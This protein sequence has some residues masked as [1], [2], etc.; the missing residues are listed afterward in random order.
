[1]LYALKN[2]NSII[3]FDRKNYVRTSADWGVVD[4]THST[5]KGMTQIGERVANTSLDTR[6]IEIVGHIKAASA[7]DMEAKKTAL[8]RMCDPRKPFFAMPTPVKQIECYATSTPKYPPGKLLNNSSVAQFTISAV[9]YDPLFR[10]A[11]PRIRRNSAGS[12]TV[13]LPNNG[14]LETGLV[15]ELTASAVVRNPVITNIDTE[16][17]IALKHVFAAGEKVII[18]TNYGAESVMSCIGDVEADIINDL[19]LES[20]FLQAPM[21]TSHIRITAASGAADLA[22][23]IRYY[24]RYWREYK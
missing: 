11:A 22:A 9:A 4:A 16:E 24:Q 1:M 13:I 5:S 10:D 21:G 2:E 3:E 20:D 14:D 8:D 18:N 7:E 15:I 12:Q 23:V 17:F 6:E 19:D